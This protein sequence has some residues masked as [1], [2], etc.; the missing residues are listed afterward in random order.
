VIEKPVLIEKPID[1]PNFSFE[2][3]PISVV[4]KTLEKAYNIQIVANEA[5]LKS[6]RM[7]ISLGNQDALFEQ[8]TVVCK[9]IG[10]TYEIIGTKIIVS[11]PGC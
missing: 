11:G 8:L 1:N 2:N 10:A 5:V 4:L 6:C 9:V 7:T 3:V